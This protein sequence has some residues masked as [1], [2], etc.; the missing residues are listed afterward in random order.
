MRLLLALLEAHTTLVLLVVR[1][2]RSSVHSV[3]S[4]AQTQTQ[5]KRIFSRT[6][7]AR[8]RVP[9]SDIRALKFKV[10]ETHL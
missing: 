3:H 6:D 10:D 8:R 1:V 5:V 9:G 7:S 4:E 2:V